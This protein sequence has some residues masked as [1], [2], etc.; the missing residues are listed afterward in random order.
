MKLLQDYD[1]VENSK[2]LGLKQI[3]ES[4]TLIVF[5][6]RTYIIP[7]DGIELVEQKFAWMFNTRNMS[8]I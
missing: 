3:A 1:F 2:R 6:G 8:I 4:K 7:Q 5:L